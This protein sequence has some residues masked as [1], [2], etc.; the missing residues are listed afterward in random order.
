MQSGSCVSTLVSYPV[1]TEANAIEVWWYTM[2]AA[3]IKIVDN[4]NCWLMDDALLTNSFVEWIFAFND[5]QLH[6][7]INSRFALAAKNDHT[8]MTA[9]LPV[10]ESQNTVESIV[11]MM[12]A[13]H[14]SSMNQQK[15]RII[16]FS[17]KCLCILCLH[18][19]IF[20][21]DEVGPICLHFFEIYLHM[22]INHPIQH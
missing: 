4:R 20:T 12:C 3:V 7:F 1:R 2:I 11:V 13:P 6:K 19:V 16:S 5:C 21:W 14:K 10:Y 9:T 17:R 15:G 8:T 22:I 18:D